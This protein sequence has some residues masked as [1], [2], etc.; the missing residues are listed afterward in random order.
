MRAAVERIV[1]EAA[2]AV[3]EG[4][5]FI[6][7]SDRAAGPERVAV[8]PLISTGAV[9]HHLVRLQKRTKVGLMVESGQPREVNHACL[10]LGYGADAV[11][12]YLAEE[13]LLALG[14]DQQIGKLAPKQIVANYH[15]AISDGLLKVMAKMGISTLASYKGAQ[16]FE[17]IGLSREVVD[18]VFCGT[19]S[20]IGGV[21]WDVL[22]GDLLK[23]HSSA[24]GVSAAE[25][26]PEQHR[27][28]NPGR[29]MWRMPNVEVTE[30]HLNDPT[31]IELLQAASKEPDFKAAQAKFRKFAD[32][33]NTLNQ[34]I[35]IRGLLTFEK[36]GRA[37]I[38][39]EEVEP[40]E[41]IAKRFCTGAMSYGS[42]S[43]E[44]HVTLARAMNAIGGRSNTGEGGENPL[45]LYPNE[46]GTANMGRSAIKQVAS[47]R[48]GVTAE[49]LTN[50]DELQIKMAQGAKPGEGGELPGAKVQGDIARTRHSTPGVGLISPP[51]HHDIYSI[52]D[53][54]ELIYDLKAANPSARVTVKLVAERGVGVVAAGVVKAK[55]DSVLISGHDGGTGAAKWTSIKH[56]G[57]P[58]ELGLAETH[59]TL[60]TNKLRGRARVQVDG[61]LRTGRDLAIAALLGAEEWGLA[62][63]PLIV[64]GCIML[65]KCHTNECSVGVATQD[66]ELRAKFAG[67]MKD[68]IQ[69][70]RLLAED[71][72]EVMAELGFRTVEEMVGH[73]ELL[74]VNSEVIATTPKLAGVDLSALLVRAQPHNG[75]CS[76]TCNELQ[77]HGLE[78][79]LDPSLLPQVKPALEDRRA[80]RIDA[81]IRNTHRATGATISHEVTKAFGKDKLAKD[82]LQL[83]FRGH[84]GQSFGAFVTS[85]MT[86]ILTGASNDYVG[87]G[88]CGGTIVVKPPEDIQY[89]AEEGY[90]VGNVCLYGATSGRGFFQRA[91]VR[92]VRSS[93]LRSDRLSWRAAA[94][95]GWST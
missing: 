40:F 44:A 17:A 12:P 65:R 7:L 69:F 95:T 89:P 35:S 47:G 4:Y 74:K 41:A 29:Y 64:M 72:R 8:C 58:W 19:Q 9:H 38:P 62:T 60:V 61:M 80:V 83:H 87:K 93:E 73:P 63:V 14:S 66:P 32:F 2:R 56:A 31:A 28:P 20:A 46:D 39:I 30:P 85:G 94:C 77:D 68:V 6:V 21:S 43:M 45:R 23:L 51:P 5:S 55:A 26:T 49:Y 59:Q 11:C 16:I 54:S 82:T 67:R 15:K 70:F 84:A 75:E 25:N 27:L 79:G 42:I 1:Q 13:V 3:D 50:A 18:V 22:A 81:E 34:Q 53:L 10:L 33:H 48:F 91:G 36:S 52:E 78:R 76:Q 88:L 37:P 24:Y 90:I 71:L 86:L 92:A 57:S